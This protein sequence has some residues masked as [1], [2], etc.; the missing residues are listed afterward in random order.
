MSSDDE[1]DEHKEKRA[2]SS[3][4]EESEE[5]SED[6]LLGDDADM[7]AV[8]KQ[9]DKEY[10]RRIADFRVCSKRTGKEP[11]TF[12]PKITKAKKAEK[13]KRAKS[14]LTRLTTD[15]EPEEK[16]T[17]VVRAVIL[18]LGMP[19]PGAQDGSVVG[20]VTDPETTLY[21]AGV[22]DPAATHARGGLLITPADVKRKA[23]SSRARR[24]RRTCSS[25]SA[26]GSSKHNAEAAMKA[27]Q[28]ALDPDPLPTSPP[29]TDPPLPL[30]HPLAH[31]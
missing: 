20:V 23:S 16:Q 26:L 5:E 3:E 29:P 8:R 17:S 21:I 13:A 30:R 12:K 15:P 25:T 22:T 18:K 28:H 4:E 7:K 24:L 27:P 9:L 31:C 2:D 11:R 14:K 10:A 1:R 19:K 6:G